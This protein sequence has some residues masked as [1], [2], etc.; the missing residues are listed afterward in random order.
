MKKT[1]ELKVTT[2]NKPKKGEF[3][4]LMPDLEY[5]PELGVVFENVKQ[6]LVPPRLILR[7]NEGGF[8]SMIE[9]PRLI[10]DSSKGVMARD[11]EAGFSGYWLVSERLHNVLS[12][13]DP[14]GFNFVECEFRMADGTK[15]PSYFLCDVVRVLDALDEEQSEVEIE[16]S[17]DFV[18]G[19]FY[20]ITGGASL[21]FR[22]DVIGGSHIFRTPFSADYYAICDRTLIDAVRDAG[23]GIKGSSDGLWFRDAA[24][25]KDA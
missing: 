24:D 12:T 6:L 9:K 5:G 1:E 18:N 2:Q 16:V 8:A 10:Y 22:K 15:G 19:K 17:E 23:I 20:D 13:I 7:P 4:I 21:S 3:Y 25:W 11:L 14:E